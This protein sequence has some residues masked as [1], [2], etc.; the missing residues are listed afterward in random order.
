MN[1]N[2]WKARCN[3]ASV[4]KVIIEVDDEEVDEKEVDAIL[5]IGRFWSKEQE[6]DL[7]FF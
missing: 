7:S 5:E 1:G 6:G 2:S 4:L 3:L